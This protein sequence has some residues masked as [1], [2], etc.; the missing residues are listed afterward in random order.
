MRQRSP[1]LRVGQ[2]CARMLGAVLLATSAGAAEAISFTYDYSF[3]AAGSNF[4]DAGTADGLARRTA[5]EAAGSF[6]EARIGDALTAIV[7][8]PLAGTS[9]T[10]IFENPDDG[11]AGTEILDLTVAAG[12]ILIIPGAR[13]LGGSVLAEASPGSGTVAS[14]GIGFL[15][16]TVTRGQGS[17]ADVTGANA[18]EFS[19]WGGTIAFDIDTNWHLPVGSEPSAGASPVTFDFLT[20]ALHEFGHVLGIGIA[21]SWDVHVDSGT[22]TFDGPA[23]VG[24]HGSDVP[25]QSSGFH[26]AEN[27]MSAVA[28]GEEPWLNNVGVL[29]EATYD[30]FIAF[31]HRNFVTDLDLAGLSDVGWEIA[32]PPAPV[33]L[34]AGGWLLLGGLVALGMRRPERATART[35]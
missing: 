7:S 31:N 11:V 34:P 22:N 29:Q 20:V 28:G 12:E 19:L 13:D 9:F 3:D 15:T 35:A 18:S 8:D 5:L 6:Y 24:V 14:G 32:N 2:S 26:W 17:I 10:G 25:L 1:R 4:F 21:Q 30:P 16:N 23:S 33:P 27:T